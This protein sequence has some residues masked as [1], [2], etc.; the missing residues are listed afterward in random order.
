MDYGELEASNYAH[1]YT[2]D[3]DME[4]QFG[5]SSL[6]ELPLNQDVLELPPKKRTCLNKTEGMKMLQS[7]TFLWCQAVLTICIEFVPCDPPPPKER[8]CVDTT[9]GMLLVLILCIM[10][11]LLLCCREQGD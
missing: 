8:T 5:S 11:S 6:M 2:D 4:A 10:M 7:C 9:E 3:S 1:S